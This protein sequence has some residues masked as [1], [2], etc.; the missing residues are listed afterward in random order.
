MAT[1]AFLPNTLSIHS[2][3]RRTRAFWILMFSGMCFWLMYQ[4][5]WNYFEVFRRQ[6]V[7]NPFLGDIVLFLHLVP[8]MA[9][10][11]LLPHLEEDERDARIRTLDF[12]LL[13]I[14]WV[15]LY[16]YSVIPWQTVY[17]NETAYSNNFNATYLTEKLV[18]LAALL[19]LTYHAH[20][21]W[22]YLYAQLLGASALYA[23]SSYVANYAI[24]HQTYYS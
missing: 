24:G 5:M 3:S 12:A 9:G 13:L 15:F 21:G 4:G 22:R 11:A 16:V 19:M 8:M 2:P 1:A 20:G 18:L 17:V 7:P 23:S 10:L 14:W 6:E